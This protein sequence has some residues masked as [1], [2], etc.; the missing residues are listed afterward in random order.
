MERESV[1]L[2]QNQLYTV[3]HYSRD[4]I[5]QLTWVQEPSPA[6]YQQGTLVF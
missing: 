2:K 3:C 6:K 5:L 1:I 4:K